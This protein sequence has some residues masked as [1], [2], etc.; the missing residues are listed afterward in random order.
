MSLT[1][2]EQVAKEIKA[3]LEKPCIECNPLQWSS[4]HKDEFPV[5]ATLAKKYLCVCGTSVP[6]EH[7]FST[8]GH[9]IGDLRN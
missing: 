3:Y 4:S 7:L 5:I 8:G 2:S 1:P 6:S 9:I